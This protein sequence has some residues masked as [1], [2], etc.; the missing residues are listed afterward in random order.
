MPNEAGE[1]RFALG[2][3][4]GNFLGPLLAAGG[5]V[6]SFLTAAL[7]LGSTIHQV[8]A[9][10]EKGGALNDLSKRTGE[11]VANLFSLEHAFKQS[12]LSADNVSTVLFQLQRALSGVNEM[13]ED[14]ATAFRALGLSIDDLRNLGSPEALQKIFDGLNT[15]NANDAAGAISKIFGRGAAAGVLQLS[16]DSEDFKNSLREAATQ[17][18]LFERN[19]AAF[20]RFGDTI[21]TI[22]L[23]IQGIFVG[24]AAAGAGP[25]QKLLDILKH[26]DGTA[27]GAGLANVIQN[28]RL[29]DLLFLSLAEGADRFGRFFASLTGDAAL[30]SNLILAGE[31]AF[32]TLGQ[33]LYIALSKPL[34]YIAAALEKMVR[35]TAGLLLRAVPGG[36]AIADKLIPGKSF[37]A[38]LGENA[39]VGDVLRDIL[40]KGL[41][42]SGAL[43]AKGAVGAGGALINAL[44][45]AG[46]PISP[47][48]AALFADVASGNLAGGARNG[49]PGLSTN[50]PGKTAGIDDPDS[51][52]RIGF[53]SGSGGGGA[54]YVRQTAVYTRQ[55]VE[56]IKNLNAFVQRKAFLGGPD[57]GN[58]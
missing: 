15:L 17:A 22:K 50:K 31:S 46:G 38:L 27:I 12:G 28:G 19:A 3:A 23:N 44:R 6:T 42:L 39:F 21:G 55:T 53:F 29:G 14:T 43:G 35:D 1:M 24:L 2:L 54:E 49:L 58:E 8:F 41:G 5:A 34:E 18:A 56:Q 7:G 48:L 32:L 25:L 20:D 26:F 37:K 33:S 11:S 52:Q 40:A 47:E 36:G 4:T 13:G 30:W 51:L 9:Q 45:A 57:F 16:R 10:I